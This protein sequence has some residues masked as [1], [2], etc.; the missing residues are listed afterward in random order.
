MKSSES[1]FNGSLGHF[2][3]GKSLEKSSFQKFESFHK[4]IS[5]HEA[6]PDSGSVTPECKK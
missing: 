4:N 1:S 2:H 3:E 6:D 5:A